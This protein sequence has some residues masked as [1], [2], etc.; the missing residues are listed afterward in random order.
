MPTNGN[1]EILNTETVR[2]CS[3]GPFQIGRHV[4]IDTLPDNLLLEL[5]AF[6]R[7]TTMESWDYSWKWHTL[8]HVCRRW[9]VIV[10]ASLHRLDLRLYCT[11][12]TPVRGN[13][14]CWPALPIIVNYWD[15]VDF[16][17]SSPED[18]DNI[19]AALEHA[20]RVSR[21]DVLAT[22]SLFGKLAIVMQE[23][24]PALTYLRL[25]SGDT[26]APVF[27]KDTFAGFVPRLQNLS[28]TCIPFPALPTLLLSASD[29]VSLRLWKIPTAGY[30]SP[31]V[32]FTCLSVLPKLEWLAIEFNSPTSRPD[33][34]S[35]RI[36]PQTRTVLPALTQFEFRG[37][38]EYLEDLVDRIDA[39]LLDHVGI[40]FFHQ[41]ILEIPQ[42]SDFVG[43]TGSLNSPDEAIV[44]SFPG[45]VSITLYQPRTTGNP[46]QVR[47]GVSCEQLDWQVSSLA[48]ICSQCLPLHSR[49]KQLCMGA[50][51]LQ[52]GWKDNM[53]PVEWLE[54]FRWFTAV[55]KLY[56]SNALAP[57]IASAFEDVE[58]DMVAD[59]LPSLRTLTF[60]GSRRSASVE[61]FISARQL[62]GYPITAC[63]RN[64]KDSFF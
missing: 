56:I 36:P 24:F 25:W 55:E 14:D 2:I 63:Y 33:W 35:R 4:T 15:D 57:H 20:D 64:S 11:Y 52:P 5:F 38:S 13:L 34:R 47:L 16:K 40:T 48:Q 10:F 29:L 37:V 23:P 45:A 44:C 1:S 7:L 49:V 61:H 17:P 9:R 46:S 6:Y 31:E 30:I 3:K 51:Y 26:I 8:V 39:P 21:I 27:P 60:S 18:E 19:I 50:G 54:V 53:D 41:L 32:M 59:I 28:M 58:G 62:S 42:V 12:G 22:S 43:R